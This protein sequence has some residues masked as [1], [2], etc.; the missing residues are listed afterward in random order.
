MHPPR[1]ES[2]GQ[3]DHV[4][5]RVLT[6]PLT[7]R[8]LSGRWRVGKLLGRGGM[9]AVYVATHR[10]G[11]AVAIKVLHPNLAGNPRSL[12]RFL[13]E[14]YIAN[15]V[16][17]D[18][19]VSVLDDDVTEDGTVFLV[20]D[21][22]EGMTLEECARERGGTLTLGEVLA[23]F[24]VVLEIL[25]AAHAKGIVHRDVKPS[26]V[27]L[28]AK[29]A[30]KLL[31]FGIARLRETSPSATS[32]G[33]GSVLG[34]PG[35]IAPE[36]A[37]GRWDAVDARTDLWSLGATMFRLLTGRFVHEGETTYESI[38]A[39]ATRD[40]PSVASVDPSLPP[41]LI[42]LLDRALRRD[43]RDRWQS[44]MEMQAA[45]REESAKLP[46]CRLPCPKPTGDPS[47]LDEQPFTDETAGDAREEVHP[48]A[49]ALEKAQPS[50]RWRPAYA[51]VAAAIAL[52]V[53]GVTWWGARSPQPSETVRE[54]V[55]VPARPQVSAVPIG[56]AAEP[57]DRP[58]EPASSAPTPSSTG[59]ARRSGAGPSASS[60]RRTAPRADPSPIASGAPPTPPVTP[61]PTRLEDVLN[62]RN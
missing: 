18:G 60:A 22:L 4:A 16:G 48:F 20:M 6:G 19:V 61:S 7:G 31:D 13:R 11:K 55:T 62:E 35:F 15:R 39:A 40:A 3:N 12:R 50:S 34:T 38:M 59:P 54:P 49:S 10:N 30:V 14:G 5:D 28:T 45:V 47:T 42:D 27:F 44:A 33:T 51:G 52:L 36:Q 53:V 17:H 9:S 57:P 23:V 21:L 46:D 41:G 8:L 37:G 26:N 25:G 56:V 29:G 58:Q 2:V 32:T 24:A 43:P 1:A